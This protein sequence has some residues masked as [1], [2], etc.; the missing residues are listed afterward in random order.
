M[1]PADVIIV[2]LNDWDARVLRALLSSHWNDVNITV[3]ANHLHGLDLAQR[4]D[5][6]LMIIDIV[7]DARCPIDGFEALQRLRAQGSRA[8]VLLMTGAGWFFGDDTVAKIV[9]LG[10][11]G[12]LKRPV[13]ADELF[14]M[15]EELSAP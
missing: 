8:R 2:A 13:N 15:I 6:D 7:R 10:G 4:E 5:P 1:T 11:S 3:T 14:S 9:Q 12:L